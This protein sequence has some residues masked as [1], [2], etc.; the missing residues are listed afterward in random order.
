[1]L[2]LIL[3]MECLFLILYERRIG[4][5]MSRFSS[6][7]HSQPRRIVGQQI[8]VPTSWHE[9]VMIELTAERLKR[10]ENFTFALDV[11]QPVY[12]APKF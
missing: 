10:C 7:A 8:I 1:M 9:S 5:S 3:G 2:D 12:F 4:S 6:T 11:P